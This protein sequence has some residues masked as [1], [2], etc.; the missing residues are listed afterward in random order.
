MSLERVLLVVSATA[1]MSGCH[2]F[3]KLT[4]DC[5]KPQ[6]YQRARQVPPLKVPSGLDSPNTQD[7]LVIPTVGV[8]PPPPGPK[9]NCLDI[10]PRYKPAP[11]NKAASG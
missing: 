1:L 9:D 11:P 4:P 6:E 5:H 8:S 10:P 7:A 3:S 2:L